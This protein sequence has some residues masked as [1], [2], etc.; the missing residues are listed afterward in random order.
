M[1]ERPDIKKSEL[2]KINKIYIISN[3]KDLRLAYEL[4]IK[5]MMMYYCVS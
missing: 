1:E 5:E 4:V 2:D 3:D